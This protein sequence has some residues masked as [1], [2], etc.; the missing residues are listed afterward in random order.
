MAEMT[1]ELATDPEL[2]AAYGRAHED[3]L[4][5][6][7][8]LGDVPEIDGHLGRWHAD[9]GQ[10]PA[11]PRR[12]LPRGRSGREPVG[13]QGD[14]AAGRTVGRG[15]SRRA[16]PGRTTGDEE[17]DDAGGGDRLRHQ[18]D[19]AA[20]RRGRP[21]LRRPARPGPADGDRPA[22]PGRRPHRALAEEALRA[23]LRG[24]RGLRRGRR[25]ARGR[26]DP[27]RRDLGDPRREQPAGVRRRHP[28]AA[29]RR[30]RGRD[31]RR[32]GRPV[33]RRRDRRADRR[34]GAATP[35]LVVDIGGGSTE[36]VRGADT[37]RGVAVGRHR[38]RPADRAPPA[39][40]PADRRRDR[41]GL[42]RHPR[43]PR[44]RSRRTSRSRASARW[45]AWPA[46]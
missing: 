29:G 13:G 21:R 45:S 4:A 12:A 31:R 22:G 36:V 34:R 39:R 42:R 15:G 30:A 25:G 41:R 37:G 24:R 32:G 43:R 3:Y 33:V 28:G 38:L 1:A 10:V 14:R 16:P 46:R 17:Q 27:L 2:A 5:R 44:R 9:P 7:A 18:L 40:R 20:G 26:A 11:R 23:H 35:F 19:P 8:A 6:R